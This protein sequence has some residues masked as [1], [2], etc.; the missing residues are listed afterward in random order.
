MVM[1]YIFIGVA[2]FLFFVVYDINSIILKKKLLTCC[3]FIGFFLITAATAGIVISTWKFARLEPLRTGICGSLAAFLF[4][5]LIYTLFFALPFQKTYLKKQES[6]QLY[7]DGVYALCRHPGVLWFIG[8]YL[9]LG[10][11]LQLTQ[12]HIAAVIFSLFNIFYVL[13]QDVWSFMK[14]FPDYGSYKKDTPFLLPNLRSIR[15]CL[16]TL[17]SE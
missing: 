17:K 5:L 11:A 1:I 3:F 13:F 14:T 9:F 16:Q 8:F 15:R 4:L 10:Q 7:K 6:P 12:L 2:A